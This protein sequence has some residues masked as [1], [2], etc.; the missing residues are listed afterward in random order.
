[1]WCLG[2]KSQL[3][4]KEQ[5]NLIFNVSLIKIG[6]ISGIPEEVSVCFRLNRLN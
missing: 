3:K 5:R 2:E 1:M 4:I 6:L